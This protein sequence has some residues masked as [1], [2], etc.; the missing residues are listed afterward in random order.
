MGK[1]CA[2]HLG[3]KAK[4]P[5]QFRRAIN[6]LGA[7]MRPISLTSMRDCSTASAQ[8]AQTATYPAARLL[9]RPLRIGLPSMT[10][11]PQVRF[12][13]TADKVDGCGA[14]SMGG[15][16]P[17]NKRISSAWREVPVFA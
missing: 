1:V 5:T 7:H 12:R 10:A 3:Q 16:L 9:R 15:V 13:G 14:L 11:D 4:L 2:G 8:F 6:E 17:K